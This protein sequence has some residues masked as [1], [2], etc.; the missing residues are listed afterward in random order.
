MLLELGVGT[1]LVGSDN[2]SEIE[3]MVSPD[4][5]RNLPSPK[6]TEDLLMAFFLE[7]ISKAKSV[8]HRTE[9]ST[10]VFGS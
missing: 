5:S 10:F 9:E 6:V 3:G 7:P 8:F 1:F 2:K 4:G